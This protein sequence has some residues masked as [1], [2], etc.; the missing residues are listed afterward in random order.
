MIQ[1]ESRLRE[2]CAVDDQKVD[3]FA[4]HFTYGVYQCHVIFWYR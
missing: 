3:K 1:Y 4:C 2:K